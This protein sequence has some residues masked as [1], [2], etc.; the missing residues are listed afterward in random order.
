MAS[1]RPSWSRVRIES[2]WRD[3]YSHA[4]SKSPRM[5]DGARMTVLFWPRRVGRDWS[6][7][8]SSEGTVTKLH[9]SSDQ[10][11]F[12]L[13]VNKDG[14]I[15]YGVSPNGEIFKRTRDGNVQVFFATKR[16]MSGLLPSNPA[17]RCWR[18]RDR[19]AD[20]IASVPKEKDRSSFRQNRNIC[21]H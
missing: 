11:I 7:G 2:N 12:A 8:V 5:G 21:S 6:F 9:E 10:Q 19:R 13:A 1:T 17:G 18:Q 14:T 16:H 15:Y 20:F 4:D 3:N